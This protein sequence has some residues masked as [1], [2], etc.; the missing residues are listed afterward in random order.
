MQVRSNACL[1]VA[2]QALNCLYV[3][4]LA[5]GIGRETVAGAVRLFRG[6]LAPFKC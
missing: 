3:F 2:K 6:Y 5:D 1:G 4:A